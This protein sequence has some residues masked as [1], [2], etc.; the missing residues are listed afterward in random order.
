MG[1][2]KPLPRAGLCRADALDVLKLQHNSEFLFPGK[3]KLQ[4]EAAIGTMMRGGMSLSADARGKRGNVGEA[5][6][7]VWVGGLRV[8]GNARGHCPAF[9]CAGDRSD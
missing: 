7:A 5:S 4:C 6:R 8:H 9:S 2:I 1:S 3:E